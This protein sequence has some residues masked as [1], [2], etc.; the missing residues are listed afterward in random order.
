MLRQLMLKLA[1]RMKSYGVADVAI[2]YNPLLRRAV[3]NATGFNRTQDAAQIRAAQE[4]LT[5]RIMGAAVKSRYGKGRNLNPKTWPILRKADIFE[6]YADFVNSMALGRIPA[7]TGGTSGT[8]IQLWRSFT[9]AAAEQVFIDQMLLPYGCDMRTS[10]VA[11]LR[12]DN[13]KIENEADP[14]YGVYSHGGKRLTLSSMHLSHDTINWYHKAIKALN[15]SILWAY[16]NAA[17]S[18][19]LLLKQAG[20]SLSIPIVLVSSETLLPDAHLAL[21]DYFHATVINYYGQA[22]RACFA[23][24]TEPGR[25]YFHPYYGLVELEA[26]PGE[27]GDAFKTYKII[28]TGF[29]NSTMPLVRYDTSDLIYLPPEYGEREIAEICM[30]LRSFPGIAGREGEFIITREGVK[31]IGLNHIPREVE[32]LAQAQIIQTAYDAVVI[33]VLPLP[34]FNE[35]DAQKLLGQTRMKLPAYFNVSL[36]LAEKLYTTE[37]GKM[38]FIVNKVPQ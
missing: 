37:R 28:G 34:G 32:H 25:F 5:A 21:E 11:V 26:M 38:P 24:S 23:Y 33:R 27:P 10:R 16:P 12:A 20:L 14:A 31:L 7:G 4:K 30:G 8:P 35:Q 2:R 13:I 22:E 29:W 17:A 18:L 1:A 36:D 19:M 3:W 9:S 6:A 15:P